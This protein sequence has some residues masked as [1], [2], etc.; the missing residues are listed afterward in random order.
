MPF[1]RTQQARVNFQQRC[2]FQSDKQRH[3]RRKAMIKMEIYFFLCIVIWMLLLTYVLWG[4][5]PHI[6]GLSITLVHD[7]LFKWEHL[8]WHL[9]W[10]KSLLCIVHDMYSACTQAQGVRWSGCDFKVS[11]LKICVSVLLLGRRIAEIPLNIFSSCI[12]GRLV[13][14]SVHRKWERPV[15]LK[16]W[17]SFFFLFFFQHYNQALSVLLFLFLVSC[18]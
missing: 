14:P 16:N 1:N 18:L 11:W 15:F 8:S 6:S 2:L 17:C 7:L 12:N 5:Y 4:R 10:P 3:F 9:T 13:C